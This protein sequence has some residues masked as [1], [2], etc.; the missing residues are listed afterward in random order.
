MKK[1][2]KF[3]LIII[4]LLALAGGVLYFVN[5][6]MFQTIKGQILQRDNVTDVE[7]ATTLYE[8]EEGI[9]VAITETFPENVETLGGI[10]SDPVVILYEEI[11]AEDAEPVTFRGTY[12]QYNTGCFADGECFAVVDGK[13]ITTILGWTQGVS[14]TFANPDLPFGTEVEVYALPTTSGNYT[15]YGSEDFY[16]KAV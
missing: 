15:L 5:P 16:I 4:I 11:I 12:E 7:Q 6:E 14:G 10:P 9:E 3:L 13:Q 2:L 8:T 1:V